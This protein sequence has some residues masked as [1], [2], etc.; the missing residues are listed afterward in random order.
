MKYLTEREG[1]IDFFNLFGIDYKNNSILIENTDGIVNGN[2]LEFKLIIND[3]SQV[4]FQSLKYL[5]NLRVKGIEVPNNIL[6]IDLNQNLAYKFNS[7][8]YFEEIH[9]VYYGASSKNNSGFLIGNYEKFYLSN[10]ID[11]IKFKKIL[12]EKK[13]MKIDIDENCIVGWAERYY[14]ENPTANKSD[15]IGDLEGKVKIIGEIREPK[16]FKD[17]INP[18]S[19]KTNEKF[20][21]LMDKLNDKLHKKEL[22]AF[23]THPL[24]SKK[25]LE[26]V[27][28]AIN[29]VPEGNDYIILDRC[30]GTGNLE[31]FLTD[32]ELSHCILSTYEYYEYKVLQERL[33]DKVRF[34]IPPIEKE[35]TYFKGFVKQANALTKEY[36]EY[37]PIKDYLNNPSCTII[38]LEN[39]PYQDSSSITYIEENNLRKRV[40]NRRKEEFLSLEFKKNILAKLNEKRG[41]AR[42]YANLFIWSAFEYYLRE[43]TDS[44]ILF[45]PVK[46]FKNIG[47]VEK[48]FLKGFIFNRKHFHATASGIS[49]ILWSNE[50]ED[51]NEYEL[52]IYDIIKDDNNIENIK[53][54]K[55]IKV[56]KVKKN[57]STHNDLRTFIDDVETDLVCN[58]DG[59]LITNYI[60]KKGRKPVYNKNIIGYISYINFNPDPK[61]F[62]LVRIN[63]WKGLEQSYGFHLREDNFMKKIP[64]WVSKQPILKWYEKDVI[65]NSADKGESYQNDE[66]FLKQCLIYT[67]LTENNRCM[68]LEKNDLII[69]NEL[70][71]DKNTISSKELKKYSLTTQEEELINLYTK[72]MN[73]IKKTVKNYNQKYTYGIYQI[74]KELNTSYILEDSASKIYDYPELN[75]MLKTL[76]IKL[77]D[78]LITNIQP[79]M[80]EYELLK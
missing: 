62:H 76:S 13:Y 70:C 55:N 42:E 74:K 14:R 9:K 41:S 68:T 45:S 48:K 23:Y 56:K 38:M 17:F 24:Y 37:K 60:Y 54:E 35:D 50:N 65:F 46:Y 7:Q 39:P 57:I 44:Y 18:Y 19:K 20:K 11:I 22:G 21:Y 69:L 75:G 28:V 66:E 73:Y 1:Q 32:E 51:K 67:C 2:I 79:K 40:K 61:N 80:Y 29:R 16:H 78:Y 12:F 30:A 59:S 4:L 8:D 58:T 5:S 36:V 33:G 53:Y 27:R 26:L 3:L 52:E 77:K 15:F 63:L 71:F 31:E 6:L 49:C 10:D 34:I 64:I 43:N 25:A 47:L 72:I